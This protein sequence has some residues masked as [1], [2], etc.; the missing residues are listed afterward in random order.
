[1][2]RDFLT[3]LNDCFNYRSFVPFSFRYDKIKMHDILFY[4]WSYVSIIPVMRSSL[5]Y[6]KFLAIAFRCPLARYVCNVS[7]L[8]VFT[9]F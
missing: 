7:F 3:C 1:M 8:M 9:P 6:L 4:K 5:R 2:I